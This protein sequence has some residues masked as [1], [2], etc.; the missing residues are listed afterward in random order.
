MNYVKSE[1]SEVKRLLQ[2]FK[3]LTEEDI[4]QEMKEREEEE[5]YLMRNED[6]RQHRIAKVNC[7]YKGRPI[8]DRELKE[9]LEYIEDSESSEEETEE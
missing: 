9:A 2:A 3:V 7:E 4:K 6:R 1:M 8:N 5:R